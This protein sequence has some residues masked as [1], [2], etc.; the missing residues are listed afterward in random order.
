MIK[1]VVKR[2]LARMLPGMADAVEVIEVA[3]T[4]C[5]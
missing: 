4:M 2:R 1:L 5:G 3:R